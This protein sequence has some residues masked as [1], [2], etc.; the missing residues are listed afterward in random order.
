MPPRYPLYP[1]YSGKGASPVIILIQMD[2]VDLA[3]QALPN[4]SRPWVLD[5][6]IIAL[7]L[8]EW[9]QLSWKTRGPRFTTPKPLLLVFHML[10]QILTRDLTVK[11]L[12]TDHPLNSLVEEA[13]PNRLLAASTQLTQ[14]CQRVSKVCH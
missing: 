5:L 8:A 10:S 11:T 2:I 4:Q 3:I 6:K 7:L 1:A 12:L 9:L 13:L 14:D